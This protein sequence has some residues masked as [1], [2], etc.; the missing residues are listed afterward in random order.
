MPSGDFNEQTRQGPCAC[1]IARFRREVDDESTR[2]DY[3]APLRPQ[4]PSPRSVAFEPL[5]YI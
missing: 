3:L 1:E 4:Q 5:R 2:Y